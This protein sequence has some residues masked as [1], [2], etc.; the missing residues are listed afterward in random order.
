MKIMCVYD[1]NY[2]L[3][4]MASQRDVV[5][6][7]NMS[8]RNVSETLA[9]GDAAKTDEPLSLACESLRSIADRARDTT[10]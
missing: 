3:R 10:G 5:G 2:G 8:E 1:P 9:R 4:S 7:A 6:R